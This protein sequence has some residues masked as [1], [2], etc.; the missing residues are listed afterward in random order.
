MT[1]PAWTQDNVVIDAAESGHC[2]DDNVFT[3]YITDADLQAAVE[4]ARGLNELMK[5]N[6]IEPAPNLIGP[7]W[8]INAP[9]AD[10]L[11]VKLGGTV[12][13]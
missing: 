10:K 9:G 12:Q 3:T 6:K 7:N 11:A 13:R 4:N 5:E 2:S 1:C 8:I